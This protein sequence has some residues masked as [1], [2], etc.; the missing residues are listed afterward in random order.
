MRQASAERQP[1]VDGPMSCGF[2]DQLIVDPANPAHVYAVMGGY[3]RAW[4]PNAGVGHVFESRDAGTTF[5]DISGNLPDAPAND[6]LITAS[7][8][9][10]DVETCLVG[11]VGK[12]TFPKPSS[13]TVKITQPLTFSQ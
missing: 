5:T 3:S 13:G 6:L 2:S 4:I 8:I 12:M 11:L 10:K 7:G 1:K 9:H